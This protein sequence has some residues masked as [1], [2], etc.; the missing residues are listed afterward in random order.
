MAVHPPEARRLAGD[1][2]FLYRRFDAEG[3]S[4]KP[5]SDSPMA[6]RPA[7]PSSRRQGAVAR[8]GTLTAL[9]VEVI[10]PSQERGPVAEIMRI[11][12]WTQPGC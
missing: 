6:L 5:L 9:R 3:A 11:V 2:V 1:V 8:R 7:M 10:D 12:V 4:V